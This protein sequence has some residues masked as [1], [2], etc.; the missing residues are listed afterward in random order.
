M[1]VHIETNCNDLLTVIKNNESK[2]NHRSE[3]KIL[4]AVDILKQYILRNSIS[5][6]ILKSKVEMAI[7]AY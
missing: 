6:P 2:T 4:D 5:D 7:S 1:T 3:D